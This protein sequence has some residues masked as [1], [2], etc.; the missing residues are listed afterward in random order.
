MS[1]PA[2]Q[3]SRPSQEVGDHD[4]AGESFPEGEEWRGL[5]PPL[6]NDGNRPQACIVCCSYVHDKDPLDPSRP[7]TWFQYW[8]KKS[9]GMRVPDVGRPKGDICIYC[10]RGCRYVA[11]GHFRWKYSRECIPC[12]KWIYDHLQDL[13]D[14]RVQYIQ[15]MRNQGFSPGFLRP[16][17]DA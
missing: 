11:G 2:E 5:L 7:V 4:V 8:T 12:M 10:E 9:R 15:Q 16:Q 17:Y 13:N 1:D 6:D 3:R 14:F